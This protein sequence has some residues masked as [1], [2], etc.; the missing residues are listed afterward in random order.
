MGF[1]SGA[2]HY[3][4]LS[5]ADRIAERRR[6]FIAAGLELMGT[7]GI[8]AT[9][10]RGV[11]EQAGLAARYF[12]ESFPTIEDL[13]VAVFDGIVTEIEERGLAAIADTEGGPRARSR[14]AL[15]ALADIL[16]TDRRKGRIIVIESASSAALGPRR[17]AEAQRF[18]GIIAGLSGSDNDPQSV[19]LRLA[20]QFVIGGVSEAMTAV[21]VGA[22]TVDR[23]HLIDMLN[24]LLFAALRGVRATAGATKTG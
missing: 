14:A 17:L 16:L 19:E 9:T 24:D 5:G 4:G 23:E 21:L 20:A 3:G 18:G 22:I 13:H 11:A 10:L 12:A 2:R 6:R 8:A 1:V 15:S 7:R